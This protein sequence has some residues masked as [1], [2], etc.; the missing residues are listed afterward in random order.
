MKKAKIRIEAKKKNEQ[1]TEYTFK[2]KDSIIL[3]LVLMGVLMMIVFTV[4]MLMYGETPIH[5]KK[6]PAIVGT[7]AFEMLLAVALITMIDSYRGYLIKIDERGVTVRAG[8]VTRIFKRKPKY[9]LVRWEE[10]DA[11]IQVRKIMPVVTGRFIYRKNTYWL[12]IIPIN[13]RCQSVKREYTVSMEFLS[14]DDEYALENIIKEL[15]PTYIKKK[16]SED[17]FVFYYSNSLNQKKR[18]ITVEKLRKRTIFFNSIALWYVCTFILMAALPALNENFNNDHYYYSKMYTGPYKKYVMK[19]S[20]PT[21]WR[22]AND[23]NT[24]GISTGS[25][26]VAYIID[27]QKYPEFYPKIKAQIAIGKGSFNEATDYDSSSFDECR[28][29]Q[30]E[31][32]NNEEISED[33]KHN[34]IKQRNDINITKYHYCHYGRMNAYDNVNLKT[35]IIL[36]YKGAIYRI[37]IETEEQRDRFGENLETDPKF[38]A[39]KKL[40]KKTVSDAIK[41]TVI[42][43]PSNL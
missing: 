37:V 34:I 30:S 42:D 35:V 23:S 19:F 7:T 14:P 28:E 21:Y 41:A 16:E 17:P 9:N 20:K 24:E 12:Y 8:G 13:G 38:L 31:D 11:I 40:H 36:D 22:Y 5:S 27:H 25:Y 32:A 43:K 33:N 10:L 18:H 26:E 4:G 2:S 29:S 3:T 6:L 39:M 1:I 15:K